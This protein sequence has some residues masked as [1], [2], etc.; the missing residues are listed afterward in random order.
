VSSTSRLF[1]YSWSWRK[2][3]RCTWASKVV[4]IWY[5]VWRY[6]EYSQGTA[7]GSAA[8]DCDSIILYPKQA[9]KH[10]QLPDSCAL[11]EYN[12]Q[13]SLEGYK[14]TKYNTEIS[15]RNSDT[16]ASLIS[17]YPKNTWWGF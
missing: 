2:G 16:A 11:K 8:F 1:R 4:T 3:L 15:P 17:Q 12:G 13:F 5:P 7:A 10:G 14:L 6:V 9:I